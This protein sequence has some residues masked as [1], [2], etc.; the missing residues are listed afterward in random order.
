MQCNAGRWNALAGREAD[1]EAGLQR[2]ADGSKEGVATVGVALGP[3][4]KIVVAAISWTEALDGCAVH[5]GE[6]RV[7]QF[8]EGAR[9][10]PVDWI[11]CQG[12]P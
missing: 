1:K 9:R 10:V 6:Q 4:G 8:A 12:G 7:V 3:R 5:V 2:A 11:I